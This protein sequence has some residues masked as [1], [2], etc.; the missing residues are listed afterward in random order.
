MKAENIAL[1]R[2]EALVITGPKGC[3]K[4]TLAREIAK[5]HGTW[6]LV[7]SVRPE[8][9]FDFS[10]Y[11]INEPDTLI[12][13]CYP[14]S[15]KLLDELKTMIASD[16]VI[17]N[18]KCRPPTVRRTPKIIICVDDD[19]PLHIDADDR[20]F[21]IVRLPALDD[22]K[23]MKG[24]KKGS[25]SLGSVQSTVAAME[26]GDVLWVETTRDKCAQVQRQYALPKSR[27]NADTKDYV[28]ECTSYQALQVATF[29]SPVILVRV[30]RKS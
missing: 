12:V 9:P 22:R 30:E 15:E 17:C 28:I 18:L 10:R 24:R 16:T 6:E 1:I 20:R 13:E 14:L 29:G 4:T 19:K 26:V 2:G 27:R 3:G 23:V 25:L 5:R 8:G 21:R 11:L 7:Y